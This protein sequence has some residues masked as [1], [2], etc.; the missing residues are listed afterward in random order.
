M[1]KLTLHIIYGYKL[2]VIHQELTQC[3]EY[4]TIK[5]C[6]EKTRMLDM[7]SQ[8]TIF[9]TEAVN[10]PK[11]FEKSGIQLTFGGN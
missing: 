10:A 4:F 11:V 6:L 2:V 1:S 5:D 8:G 3:L 9:K 7:E